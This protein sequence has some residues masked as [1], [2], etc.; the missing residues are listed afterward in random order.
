MRR[1]SVWMLLVALVAILLPL[2]SFGQELPATLPAVAAQG[3]D[4]VLQYLLGAGPVGALAYGAWLLGKGISI[5]IQVD[6]AEEDRKMIER[7]VEAVEQLA[8]RGVT[9]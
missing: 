8:A 7:G 1:P 2:L 6:L 3:L 4:P 5:R 9:P